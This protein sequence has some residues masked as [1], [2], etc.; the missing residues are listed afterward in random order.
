VDNASKP[1]CFK[2]CVNAALEAV[3][4]WYVS[5]Q[6]GSIVACA[7]PV[8]RHEASAA[9]TIG[10]FPD[11]PSTV[12]RLCGVHPVD[13][14]SAL[15]AVGVAIILGGVLKDGLWNGGSTVRPTGL[16]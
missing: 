4:V 9:A 3:S 10:L 5:L 7:T 14:E 13:V 6:G 12:A 15:A 2:I 16:R 11:V 8:A 1:L